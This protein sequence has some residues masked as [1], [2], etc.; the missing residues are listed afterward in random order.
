[1]EVTPQ[2][3]PLPDK[4]LY[5]AHKNSISF[6]FLVT[7]EISTPKVFSSDKKNQ[8]RKLTLLNEIKSNFAV[9]H[10]FSVR[11]VDWKRNFS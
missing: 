10:I 1:M 11:K 6:E 3:W 9:L 4:W 2:L 5:F 7:N 8:G